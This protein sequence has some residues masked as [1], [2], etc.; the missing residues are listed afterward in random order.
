MMSRLI[1]PLASL[2]G[3]IVRWSFNAY[4][5]VGG[6]Q[7]YLSLERYSTYGLV[8]MKVLVTGSS[9][10]IGSEAVVYYDLEGDSVFGIDNNMRR[11]FFGP[12]GDT[13]WN[14]ERLRKI[15]KR[16]T[17]CELDIRDR[18]KIL[19]FF[20]QN[21]FDV[22]VHCAAQPSHDKAKEIMFPHGRL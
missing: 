17:H 8:N 6:L 11:E 9:G 13:R 2:G 20:Q 15:T 10:L 12:N 19:D 16:F 18:Q 22:I 3:I 1:S 4:Y 21:R 7:E 5:P 14:L